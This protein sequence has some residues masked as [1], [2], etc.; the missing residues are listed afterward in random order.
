MNGWR[1]DDP[2]L[3]TWINQ[4]SL[5]FL[6]AK[7]QILSGD[8][9]AQWQSNSFYCD[10]PC[11]SNLHI[12]PPVWN[13]QLGHLCFQSRFILFPFSWGQNSV[14]LGL[15][16]TVKEIQVISLDGAYRCHLRILCCVCLIVPAG[17]LEGV[18]GILQMLPHSQALCAEPHAGI[19]NA[20]FW[21]LSFSTNWGVILHKRMVIVT[22]AK[23]SPNESK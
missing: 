13:Q 14:L 20:R 21:N 12:F 6:A 3:H 8:L 7:P 16:A 5:S 9:P 17:F 11:L 22:A 10:C 15:Q 19:S 4:T 1:R 18:T 23:Q 2:S